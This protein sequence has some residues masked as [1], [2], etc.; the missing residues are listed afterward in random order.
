MP[1]YINHNGYTVH[2]TGP[3][4]SVIKI[5]SRQKVL[6]PEYY[7][8]Y[9]V[10]GFI[11]FADE[12]L[13]RAPNVKTIQ[14]RYDVKNNASSKSAKRSQDNK[15]DN[16]PSQIVDHSAMERRKRR[17]EAEEA[18]RKSRKAAMLKSVAVKTAT[19]KPTLIKNDRIVGRELKANPNIILQQNLEKHNYPI[20]NGI[21][22]GILSYN[23]Y[24]SLKRCIDS[25]LAYT[26]LTKT[27]VFISDDASNDERTL[28]Y[29]ESLKQNG[30]LVIINN[31]RRLG[32]AGNS[33]RLLRCLKRFDYGILLND[34]V[35]VTKEGWEHFYPKAMSATGYHHFVQKHDGVYGSRSGSE[36][37]VKNVKM[38]RIDDKPQGAVLA[39]T[40]QMLK[41]CGYF[42]ESYGL[43]GM[44]HVDWSSRPAEF[45]MQPHGFY[46]I[47]RS[48]EYFFLNKE[49][50]AVADRAALL[51]AAKERF[52]S[53]K[54]IKSDP[55]DESKVPAI[56]YIIPFRN[57]ERTDSIITV[58]KNIRAQK[59]PVINIYLVEQ[60]HTTKIDVSAC[61]PVIY[62][63][64]SSSE[65]PLF[66]K[67][68]AFN[69]AASH[70]SDG[71]VIMH[72][73]DI[74]APNFYTGAVFDILQT[75]EACH[76]GATVVYAD[77]ASTKKINESG[78][79]PVDT[80]C[81]RLVGY[82]EG[83]SLACRMKAYWRAGAFNQDFWGYGCEDCDFYARLAATSEW[84]E[85]RSIDF[86]HLYHGRVSGWDAH[87]KANK[88][89]DMQLRTMTMGDRLSLQY[90]QLTE[91]GYGEILEAAL[92]D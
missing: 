75:Y 68:M 40:H 38:I 88:A 84:Y 83:G 73:A 29:L 90:K 61:G 32:V 20:S 11:K 87:H 59:F 80:N 72:D 58:V 24:E 2:L 63:L 37:I 31:T 74:L 79:I 41:T 4:G 51:K 17:K 48:S 26:D 44:E 10:R 33:N 3:D 23:R 76:I 47:D 85:K 65:N 1:E 8:R 49:E 82:Y 70:I 36:S 22:V 62:D 89:K 16:N 15:I 66:N 67:S 55:S 54:L 12:S 77:E 92:R 81:E 46:D 9:R 13:N 7:D 6:L 25:V 18:L 69:T 56:S 27:T 50:S 21:G 60:D 45:K 42:D 19:T 35:Q 28:S 39:F 78:V 34:D 91:K 86:L 53:R 52:N 30:N 71:S 14:G 64:V 57:T 5:R 43:Y